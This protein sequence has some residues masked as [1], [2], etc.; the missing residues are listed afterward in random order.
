M[1]ESP[2]GFPAGDR[3]GRVATARITAAVVDGYAGV[4]EVIS[5]LEVLFAEWAYRPRLIPARARTRGN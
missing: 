1:L 4:V 2:H 3:I 5:S